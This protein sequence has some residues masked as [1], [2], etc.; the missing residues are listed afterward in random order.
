MQRRTSFANLLP[1]AVVAV[2]F[3][4]PKSVASPS[5]SSTFKPAFVAASAPPL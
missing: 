2:G 1:S 5:R 4:S 3:T